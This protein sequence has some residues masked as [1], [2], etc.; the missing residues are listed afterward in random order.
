MN[1]SSAFIHIKIVFNCINEKCQKIFVSIFVRIFAAVV[2]NKLSLTRR[3]MNRPRWR[4]QK[5]TRLCP[6]KMKSPK[7]PLTWKARPT[8]TFLG[9]VFKQS[10]NY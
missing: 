4:R 2:D 6:R 9:M 10:F 5:L 1:I 3:K 7:S 8:I